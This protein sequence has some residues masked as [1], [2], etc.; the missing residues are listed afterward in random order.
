MVHDHRLVGEL[1]LGRNPVME[2]LRAGKRVNR[3][4]VTSGLKGGRIDLLVRE[5]R[6]RGIPVE[7]IDK[8]SLDRMAGPY[9]SLRHQ[10]V[11]ATAEALKY[12]DVDQILDNAFARGETPLLLVLDGIEDPMNL[13][14]ILRTAEAA[15]VSGVV[16]PKRRAAGITPSVARASAGAVEHLSIAMVTNTVAAIRELKSRGLWVAGLD[17]SGATMWGA[18]LKGPLALVIGSEGKG[19]AR[20]VRENCDFLVGIP[21]HGRVGSLNASVAAGLAVYEVI[22]QRSDT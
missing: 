9:A 16:I 13:G 1:I 4:F 2:A 17:A 6:N 18:D 14:S 11:V 22:R 3:V 8:T 12:L 21:M 5:A 20:L 10:G 15:G 19:L 7:E